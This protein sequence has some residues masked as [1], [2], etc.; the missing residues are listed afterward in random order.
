MLSPSEHALLGFLLRRRPDT[1]T[2]AEILEHV[3][4]YAAE[5]Q[6]NLIN[7]HVS[8]LRR[9]LGTDVVNIRA[10]RGVGY[11]LETREGGHA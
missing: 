5:T 1:V 3:F 9:K 11:R 8:N 7:V 2:R 10:V 6:T 4:G